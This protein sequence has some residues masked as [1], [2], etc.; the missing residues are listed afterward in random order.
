MKQ[1]EKRI[2]YLELIVKW[3]KFI[4]YSTL[5]ICILVAIYSLLVEK[6]Y[7]SSAKILPPR[8]ESY[9]SLIGGIANL[10]STFFGG[11]QG[12]FSL[13]PLTSPSEVYKELLESRSLAENLIYEFDLLN[14]YESKFIEEGLEIFWANLDIEV[15]FAGFVNITFTDTDTIRV[16]ELMD[17]LLLTLDSLN[18]HAT[19]N[20]HK[21]NRLYFE[22]QLEIV[23]NNLHQSEEN[24]KEFQEEYGILEITEQIRQL[25]QILTDLETKKMELVFEKGVL[26]HT[27]NKN[28]AQVRL[29]E[30]QIN[31]IEREIKKIQEGTNENLA[32]GVQEIPDLAI[33]YANLLREQ[34]I[35]ETINI[36][37]QQQYEQAKFFEE[38]DIPT[39]MVL[40]KPQYPQVRVYPKRRNMVIIAFMFSLFL[41][42]LFI[43]Y[44]E[45]VSE[46]Q[47]NYPEEYSK[48]RNLLTELF[49]WKKK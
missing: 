2:K 29:L 14:V 35:V 12:G 7:Q 28:S 11:G 13:P 37:I 22:K 30:I 17:R 25:L 33:K 4:I 8:Q 39:I 1:I 23:K 16:K 32:L 38:K 34:Q 3:K 42:I 21:R 40:D 26:D 43:A 10:T 18:T 49:R 44:K 24:L 48:L 31:S 45:K 36:F 15:T 6:K 5:I 9:G 46:I 47:T 20:Y 41:N 19:I 27:L